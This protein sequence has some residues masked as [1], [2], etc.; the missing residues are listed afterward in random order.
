MENAFGAQLGIDRTFG[1]RWFGISL[2]LIFW[3]DI[4]AAFRFH[5]LSWG[6][7]TIPDRPSARALTLLRLVVLWFDIELYV[8]GGKNR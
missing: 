7:R 3:K 8:A 2:E 1:K 5:F 4:P 6:E